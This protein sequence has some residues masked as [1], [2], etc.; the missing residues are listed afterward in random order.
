MRMLDET[1][2]ERR[3]VAPQE[4]KCRI[5]CCQGTAVGRGYL[6]LVPRRASCPVI[7]RRCHLSGNA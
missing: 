1:W 5:I 3:T 6:Y 7:C 2:N 4:C